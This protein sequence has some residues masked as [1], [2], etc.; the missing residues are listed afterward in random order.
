MG[1]S[2]EKALSK[3]VATKKDI[4][5]INEFVNERRAAAG[6]SLSRTNKITY[7]LIGWRRFMSSYPELTIGDVYAGIEARNNGLNSKGTPFMQNTRHDWILILKQFLNWL[8]ENEYAQLP[9]KKIRRIKIPNANPMTKT[10]A[11]LLT[12]EEV[13][14]LIATCNRSYD[15]TII[16]M[17]YEGE[18][19]I[20]EVGQMKWGD[21][22]FNKTGLVVNVKFKTNIPRYIPIIAL[23]EYIT[24]WRADYPGFPEGDSPVF[25]KHRGTRLTNPAAIRQIQRLATRA[26]IS[27]H[28]TPHLF[29][30]SRITHMVGEGVSESVIKLILWGSV[31]SNMLRTYAHLTGT[32]IDIEMRRFYGLEDADDEESKSVLEPKICP[33][34]HMIMPPVPD[35]CGVC[36]ES[37][38]TEAPANED[39][40]QSFILKHGQ[41]LIEY[42]LKNK[43]GTNQ[44][45]VS[46]SYI[47]MIAPKI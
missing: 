31:N 16:T 12:Q 37:L 24:Q 44:A 11:S 9:E 46:R 26:G 47:S 43:S 5:L 17:I 35:Y 45:Q 33:N 36:G 28:I 21:I 2:V 38:S 30:H 1:R 14:L 40:I 13:K 32:E 19:R 25:V 39:E 4:S 20:G 27:K 34:C 18:M 3:G 22:T 7:T 23:K 10:A 41:D 15:R 6:I 29:L 8:I 42:L